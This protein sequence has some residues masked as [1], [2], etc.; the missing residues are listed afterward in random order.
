M[1]YIKQFF[2][3][4][5]EVAVAFWDFIEGF[6]GLAVLAVSLVL[7]ALFAFLAWR[8]REGGRH[9]WLSTIMGAMAGT[10]AFWWIFGILPSAFVYFTDAE[11]DLLEG[12]VMPTAIPGADNFFEVFRDLVFAGFQG[13]ALLLFIVAAVW[14]QKRYPR[15]LAEGEEKE[16]STGGYK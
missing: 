9:G 3:T 1:E 12:T 5:P 11:R 7:F 4:L 8:W 15:A 16:P 6:Y 14:I 10:V 13:L 2:R